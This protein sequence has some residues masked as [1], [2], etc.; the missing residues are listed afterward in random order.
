[1]RQGKRIRPTQ[2]EMIPAD[3]FLKWFDDAL[4][5]RRMSIE[6]VCRQAGVD[7]TKVRQARR[8]KMINLAHADALSVAL[9]RP[10][11]SVT[12]QKAS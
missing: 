10:D 11:V 3:D 5:L 8:T 12:I 9:G 6:E 2:A 1:L 7:S 4:R